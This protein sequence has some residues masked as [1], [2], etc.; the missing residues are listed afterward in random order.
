MPNIL[1]EFHAAN[2][3]KHH[4]WLDFSDFM[5][6]LMCDLDDLLGGKVADHNPR[7]LGSLPE[8]VDSFGELF[9][10]V[11][12]QLFYCLFDWWHRFLQYIVLGRV[13]NIIW[14]LAVEIVVILNQILQGDFE[15][16][17]RIFG[18]MDFIHSQSNLLDEFEHS[19]VE[20]KQT[21]NETVW[22]VNL[23]RCVQSL[24]G[25]CHFFNEQLKVLGV[26]L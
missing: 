9:L 18:K 6:E 16:S 2:W 21:N 19:V 23:D 15:D 14:F 1:C 10:V 26:E 4:H 8:W 12:L 11:G 5:L 17:L 13:C 20:S 7:K 24:C 3:G 22:E 25:I